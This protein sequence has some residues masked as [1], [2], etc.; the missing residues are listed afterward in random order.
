MRGVR[1]E[2]RDARELLEMFADRPATLFYLDPPYFVK[3]DHR[4]VID[5]KDKKFHEE[6]LDLCCKSRSMLLISGYDNELYNDRLSE[7]D[8]WTRVKIKTHTRDTR[9]MDY[10]RTEVLWKNKHFVKAE[11]TGKVPIRLTKQEIKEN[12][13]NPPRKR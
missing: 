3:R 7:R 9:G 8:G 5:A 12:K 13:I 1:V 10:A 2:N 4:Y 6:L 11:K